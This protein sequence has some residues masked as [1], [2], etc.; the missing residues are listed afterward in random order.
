MEEKEI[1]V[2]IEGYEGYYQVSNMGRVRSVERTVWDNRG[3]YKTVHEKILRTRKNGYGY[4]LITL[5]QAGK[6]KTYTVHRLVASAFLDNSDNL[7]EVNHK[8]EDKQN[9]CADNL[10][11]CS[12]SY[13]NTYNGRAKKAGKKASEKLKGR[14][15]SEECI[16]KRA[17]KLSKPI[18][19][20][21]RVT[22]LIVEFQSAHEVER[23][24]GIAQQ[25][26]CACCKGKQKTA[27]NF[28]WMYSNNN[29]GDTE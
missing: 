2:D 23:Q 13:N 19:G 15:Q 22:G 8:D 7:P 17:E 9:N 28:Y 12:R 18:I 16:K 3:Y 29:D 6:S 21:D 25:S 4:V 20:I 11:Y 10:E 5:N 26:I 24:L 1:W 14:K 27:G